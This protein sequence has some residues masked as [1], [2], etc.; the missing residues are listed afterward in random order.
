MAEPI[1]FGSEDIGGELLPILTSGLYRDKLDTLREY[2]QN[3]IDAG[4]SHIELVIDPDVVSVRD[5]G[6][7]MTADQARNSIRLGISE[8]NPIE[9]VGFR[10]IGIYSAFN[11]CDHLDIF[12]RAADE[13][14]G[15]VIRFDFER[16]RIA[17][18]KEAER[19]KQGLRPSLYLEKLLQESVA[20]ER[21]GSERTLGHGTLAVFQGLMRDVYE[22]LNNWQ[23][24]TEYLEN[25]VPLPFHPEFK[26]KAQIEAKFEQEDYGVV[27]LL[28]QIG[29]RREEIYRPY[30]NETFTFGGNHDPN[31]FDAAFDGHKLGFAWACI[32]DARKVLKDGNLRGILIKKKGFSISNRSFLESYFTRTVFSRRMTGELIVQ[33]DELIPNAARSDFEHNA[34][35]QVFFHR[36][37][38]R[39]ISQISEWANRIQEEEKA[40]EM[41]L[42]KSSRLGI[43]S[44]DLPTVQRDREQMLR[45]NIEL[46][47]IH[48]ELQAHVRILK[49]IEPERLANYDTL[50]RECQQTVHQALVEDRQTRRKLEQRVT[51]SVQR[52]A[53]EP[54]D[55]E[56]AQLD[57]LPANLI[58]LLDAYGLME[59]PEIRRVIQILDEEVLQPLLDADAYLQVIQQL[60]ESLEESP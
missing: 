7:G 46:A 23:Q 43:I 38:P 40:R 39:L 15:H 51:K 53:Q 58:D 6:V 19:R 37:L 14:G 26:Y 36:A 12:T 48:R 28:L 8:K 44:R 41:L 10:G 11:L 49:A 57:N 17:L 22:R 31:F 16:M 33:S 27:P 56:K 60:R 9:N 50:L 1:R 21:D 32:N 34:T 13:A 35:R 55:A 2:I 5:D 20:V 45:L 18:L 29:A 24:V 4:A 47:E 59:S 3:A 52:E 25:V 42:A 54:T 30:R